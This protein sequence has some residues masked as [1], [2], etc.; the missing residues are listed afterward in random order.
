MDAAEA[1]RV[2]HLIEAYLKLPHDRGSMLGPD[3]EDRAELLGREPTVKEILKRLDP[4]L[5]DL[6]PRRPGN[7]TEAARDA[8][9]SGLGI[10]AEREEWEAKLAP[11][12]RCCRPT[13]ST[14][15]SGGAQTLWDSAHYRHAVQAA[16][17]AIN[18]HTQN[19][20]GRRDIADT[21]LMQE[22]FSPNPPEPGKPRLRC[23]GDPSNPTTQSR[24][25]GAL[26]YAAGAS[27]R[28]AT[29]RPTSKA[30]GTS[31]RRSSAWPP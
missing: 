16:A 14:P 15:G 11:T 26:Q 1:D 28:S 25:R 29:P 7:W 17:T 22:T 30:S 4:E 21:Q 10:L 23:P 2:P 19:K 12:P 20:L 18:D 31:R 3:N 8:V 5:T 9:N 6:Q 27:A 13:S 24:Q